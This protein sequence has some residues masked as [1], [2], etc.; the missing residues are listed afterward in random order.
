M[1]E[2]STRVSPRARVIAYADDGMGLH[3]DRQVL[4]HGQ[5]RLKTWLAERGWRLNEAKRRSC[6]TLEG[7]QPGGACLGFAIRPSRVGTHQS[8][9]GRRGCGRLGYNSR[10]KP[11]KANSKEPLAE[12]GRIMQRAK[13]L[14]QGPLIRQLNPTIRGW[15][16]DYRTGV[17]PAVDERLDHLTWAKLRRWARGRPPK[18]SSAWGIQRYWPRLGARLTFATAA[19]AADA[20]YLLT[21]SEGPITR[22]VKVQGHRS[23]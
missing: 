19:T 11:A 15:A 6:P 13:A 8:G 2:A 17:S 9:Q 21:H 10:S 12:L 18:P 14:P 4:E 1:E 20:V 22:H 5:Q 7:E 3:E 16:N 23:P